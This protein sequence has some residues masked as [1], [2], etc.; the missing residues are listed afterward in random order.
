MVVV[1]PR[2]RVGADQRVARLVGGSLSC[3]CRCTPDP[4]QG[5][6]VPNANAKYSGRAGFKVHSLCLPT[7]L[8]PT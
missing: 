5:A 4:L 3:R 2:R 8:I 7:R 6:W 1:P